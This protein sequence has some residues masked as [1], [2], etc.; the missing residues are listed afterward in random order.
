MVAMAMGDQIPK[1]IAM[2]LFD[3]IVERAILVIARV[4]D[5]AGFPLFAH[6]IGVA[7]DSAVIEFDDF[8]VFEQKNKAEALFISPLYGAFL[9]C[10]GGNISSSPS[11]SD[12][13]AYCGL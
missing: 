5:D 10:N 8:H 11:C 12:G 7:F 13:S 3:V 2:V 9:S 1:A 4:D 6:D